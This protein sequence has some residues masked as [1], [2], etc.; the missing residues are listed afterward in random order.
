M[1]KA[2]PFNGFTQEAATF[3][4]ELAA[5]NQRAWFARHKSIYEATVLA[6]MRHLVAELGPS[7]LAIDPA[8]DVRPQGG[9]VSR[10]YRDTRFSKDKSPFRVTQWIVFKPQ[11]RDWPNRPAFFMEFGPNRYRYGMGFYC[12]AAATMAAIRAHIESAPDQCLDAMTQALRAGYS[13]EGDAY[14]RPRIPQN[15]PPLIQEW[16]RRKTAYVVKNKTTDAFFDNP[17]LAEELKTAFAAAAPLYRFLNTPSWR[18]PSDDDKARAVAHGI[19]PSTR[20]QHR[21]Y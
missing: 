14:K 20:Q 8:F 16:Y 10:L 17:A 3:L 5:N 21:I 4:G 6:P 9:A 13:L 18:N 19:E 12:A 15:Q 1:T 7:M 11:A 2:S